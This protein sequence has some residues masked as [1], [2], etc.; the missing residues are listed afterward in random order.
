MWACERSVVH[1]HWN[2]RGVLDRSLPNWPRNLLSIDMSETNLTRVP[3][4]PHGVME[5]TADFSLLHYAPKLPESVRVLSCESAFFETI[6]IPR[7]AEV[8]NFRNCT[9]LREVVHRRPLD[10]LDISGTALSHL[11]LPDTVSTLIADDCNLMWDWIP[12]YCEHF[13][14]KNGGPVFFESLPL[15]IKTLKIESVDPVVL[16]KWVFPQEFRLLEIGGRAVA[17][18]EVFDPLE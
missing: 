13:S 17:L 8:L 16:S 1:R 5:F 14:A 11:E 9:Y 3:P 4:V 2:L 12:L 6:K 18:Q 10:F 15:N 7:R